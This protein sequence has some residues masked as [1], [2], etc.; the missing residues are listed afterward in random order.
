MIYII[1]MKTILQ[2]K[3]KPSDKQKT[4]ILATMNRFNE[5]CDYIS[6]IAFEKKCF[7]KFSLHK[8]VY[9]DVKERFSLSAQVVVRAIGKVVDSYKLHKKNQHSFKPTGAV[10]YDQRI[11]AFRGV[12]RVSLW[13]LEGRQIIPIIYG[14]Y[15]KAK[16]FQRKG[17]ADLVY[18]KGEFYLLVSV[19]TEELPP[20]DPQGYIGVDLGIVEIASDSTGESFSGEVIDDKRVRFTKL[21]KGLQSCGS[22]SAKR[23]LKKINKQEASFRRDINHCISKRI[24]EKAKRSRCGIVLEDLTDIRKRM[25][26]RKKQRSKMHG[27]S[28]AQL[29]Q[30]LTYKAKVAGV[31]V[32]IVDPRNTSRR[33]SMCGHID[34]RNR[35]SQ[36]EFVCRSCGFMDNADFNASKNLSFL[37]LVSGQIVGTDDSKRLLANCA[38][39]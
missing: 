37:G 7:S 30:F 27:W 17:Q 2:I 24:V 25:K 23:H 21:R 36:A 20:I 18:R 38:I 32:V 39:A 15:Q 33:C 22:K 29:R 3:L 12:D 26:A 34:K 19:E 5:A 16:W 9:Y 31:P 14:E 1:T 8:I 10:I 4:V 35:K 28:F 11:M 6:A 13:T